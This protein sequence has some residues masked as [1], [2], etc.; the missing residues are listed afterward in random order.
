MIVEAVWHDVCFVKKRERERNLRFA[1]ERRR[2]LGGGEEFC[3]S[4]RES[5]LES[6]RPALRRQVR[7]RKPGD[8]SRAVPLAFDE[9]GS[10]AEPLRGRIPE[11]QARQARL[12]LEQGLTGKARRQAW[13]ALIGRRRDCFS[14]NAEHQFYTRCFCGNRYCPTC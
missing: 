11:Q 6:E 2:G 9:R 14:G 10:L 4:E 13:C 7:N 8:P 5:D 12:L 3:S 1:R